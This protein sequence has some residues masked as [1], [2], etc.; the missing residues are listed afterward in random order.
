M[1]SVFAEEAIRVRDSG[2]N[3]EMIARATGAARSTVRD[4]FARRSS[5]PSSIAYRA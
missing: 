5:R 3:D 1:A 4:W 2:L